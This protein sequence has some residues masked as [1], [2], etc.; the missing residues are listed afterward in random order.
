MTAINIGLG[1]RS[2][3]CSGLRLA[4]KPVRSAYA[5]SIQFPLENGETTVAS[6]NGEL[7]LAGSMT[8]LVG[9]GADALWYGPSS[10]LALVDPAME[11]YD[12][13]SR[14]PCIVAAHNAFATGRSF[15]LFYRTAH[16]FVES[17]QRRFIMH[18]GG[19]PGTENWT[20]MG[21][22]LPVAARGP[23]AVHAWRD[24][25]VGR[26]DVYDIDAGVWYEGEAQSVPATFIGLTR[27]RYDI[28]IGGDPSYVFP[29][30]NDTKRHVAH[31]WSGSIAS[32]LFADTAMASSDV[33]AIVA[34]A[35]QVEQIGGMAK[36]RLFL[37]MVDTEGGIDLS[38]VTSRAGMSAELTQYGTLWPGPTLVRQGGGRKLSLDRFSWPGH[39]G[40]EAGARSARV[41]ISGRVS[42]LAGDLEVG[43]IN[44]AGRTVLA[45]RRIAHQETDGRFTAE[46]DLPVPVTDRFQ[47]QIRMSEDD[48][49][50]ASSHYAMQAGPV[51]M[52][53]GQ[54]E[55]EYA[56]IAE[57]DVTG[58]AVV[59]P[60]IAPVTGAD[61]VAFMGGDASMTYYYTRAI[62]KAPGVLGAPAMHIANRVGAHSPEPVALV[63]QTV[64]GTSLFAVI[65]DG[66]AQRPWSDVLARHRVA[67]RNAAGQRIVTAHI[68][69]GSEAYYSG[70]TDLMENAYVPLLTGV[71]SGSAI[72]QIP[73]DNIDHWLFDGTFS[74]NAKTMI[75]PANRSVAGANAGEVDGSAE[76][77]QRDT[78]RNWSH[79]LDYVV[80]PEM[81]THKMQSETAS[82]LSSSLV[83]QPL[84]GDMQGS[85]EMAE[86]VAQAVLTMLDVD[87]YPGPVFFE[88]VSPGSAANKLIVTLG[89]PRP[90]PGLGLFA[91]RVGRSSIDPGTDYQYNLHTKFADG[92]AGI[93]F[94]AK[95][96]NE[97]EWS[98]MNVLYGTI[99]DPVRG[100]VELTLLSDAVEGQTQI[101]YHPGGPGQY[102]PARISQ[103]DWRAGALYFA[104]TQGDGLSPKDGFAVAGSNLALMASGAAIVATSTEEAQAALAVIQPGGTLELHG[105]IT[106]WRPSGFSFDPP[107]TIDATNAQVSD[108]YGNS[109]SGLIFRGGRWSPGA[110]YESCLRI[111]GASNIVADG[112]TAEGND[113][114]IGSAVKLSDGAN[115]V[116]RNV[117]AR[118]MLRGV[119][120]TGGINIEVRDVSFDRLGTDGIDL[121]NVQNALVEDVTATGFEPVP[122]SHPDLIQ[123]AS[124][125][126]GT[127]KTTDVTV[128]RVVADGAMQG[129][130]AFGNTTSGY[131]L[132]Y[133]RILIEDCI[134]ELGYPQAISVYNCDGVIVRN[135]VVSTTPGSD[136]Q[137]NITFDSCANI[138]RTGNSVAAYG[139]NPAV[140]D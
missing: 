140:V 40:R 137:A 99:L 61:R 16:Y 104:G 37:P 43:A 29:K 26:L 109:L 32:L 50:V 97:G 87:P 111:D 1:L 15:G 63:C 130:T 52:L 128:R 88:T 5:G 35:D 106:E 66:E 96:T 76:A 110:T 113:V 138:T 118:G 14:E 6:D 58:N 4:R 42:D 2:D 10:I 77:D 25:S 126:S 136:Y 36:C 93:G 120:L 115:W 11:R 78:M 122:G 57:S 45:W 79:V 74:D 134:L 114:A 62:G 8:G 22:Q 55:G 86:G 131:H 41:Q 90:E 83:T 108:F 31:Q 100:E 38:V 51:F 65:D 80:G 72:N 49:I 19:E 105:N 7:R 59:S 33:E 117:S 112:I 84:K 102:D 89:K 48:T 12:G 53:W 133:E 69:I 91:P 85:V 139:T 82:G 18:M 132:G 20:I 92:E 107:V 70:T 47:I 127:I 54:S 67:N 101:R 119:V 71:G 17:D 46:F 116:V 135:N 30:D 60:A 73:Q 121:F 23:F 24:A 81:V 95:L 123:M 3:N 98:A 39:I 129:V 94:E 9:T 56:T 125:S 44:R 34:G 64:S 75:I 103:D 13:L 27:L 68:V 124:L 21:A 28:A